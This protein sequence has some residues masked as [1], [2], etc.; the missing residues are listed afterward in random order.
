MAVL[1]PYT[2]AQFIALLEEISGNEVVNLR[3]LNLTQVDMADADIRDKF[4]HLSRKARLS[5]SQSPIVIDLSHSDISGRDFSHLDMRHFILSHCNADRASFVGCNLTDTPFDEANLDHADL[6]KSNLTYTKLYR[7]SIIGTNFADADMRTTY[8]L[9]FRYPSRDIISRLSVVMS[10]RGAKFSREVERFRSSIQDK[11]DKNY[12]KRAAAI[13]DANIN[14]ND[15][16][17]N[18]W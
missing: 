8:G 13:A 6:R 7:T 1:R 4:E 16:T 12:P 11:I 10:I 9:R 15:R 5:P 2:T 3:N 14:Q 18:S 17:A